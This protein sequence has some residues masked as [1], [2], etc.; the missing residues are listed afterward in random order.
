MIVSAFIGI[1]LKIFEAF[2]ELS[3]VEFP[4]NVQ[5]L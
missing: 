2:I 4:N 1:L 3:Q 5:N